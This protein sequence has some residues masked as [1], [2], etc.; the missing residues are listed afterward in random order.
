MYTSVNPRPE[1]VR[2][3]GAKELMTLV[4]GGLSL[5][6]FVQRAHWA[7]RG[8]SYLPFHRMFGEVYEGLSEVN[9]RLAER[10]ASLGVE[11]P[12]G[13]ATSVQVPALPTRDGLKLC[14]SLTDGFVAYLSRIYE[15]YAKLEELRLV[16]DCN[17]VQ[18][19][20]EDVEKLGTMIRNHTL[21]G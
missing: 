7:T 14:A 6:L 18:S 20:A 10:A 9:D 19:I 1:N 5:A 8:P 15:V 4:L 21:E 3:E 12:M 16:A 11:D 2:R 17:A 13:E